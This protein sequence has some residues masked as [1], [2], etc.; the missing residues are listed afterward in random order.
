MKKTI[1][2]TFAALFSFSAIAEERERPLNIL[3]DIIQVDPK[4]ESLVA[5]GN[6]VAVHAPFRMLS[7]GLSRD[8]E[9]IYHF[10]NPTMFT[11]CTNEVGNLH[12]HV[13]GAFDYK[14]GDYALLRDGWVHL[15]ELPLLWV[16]YLRVPLWSEEGLRIMPGYA[17]RWGAFLMTKYVYHIAGKRASED[18]EGWGLDGN[19]RFDLRYKQGVAAGQSFSWRLGEFGQGRF[20]AYYA[21]DRS[22]RYD[23]YHGDGDDWHHDHW[24]SHISDNRYGI[25]FEHRWDVTE[26]DQ[27]RAQAA[28]F[29]DSFF[30]VDFVR[31]SLFMLKNQ[32]LGY[33]ANELAWEH[34]ENWSGFGVSVSGPLNDFIAGT[35]RLPEFYFDVNPLPVF[36]LPVNYESQ[37]RV[38]YLRRQYAKFGRGD[39]VT[40]YNRCPGLWADYDAVRFDT[41]HRITAPMKFADVL[42]V[43]PRVAYRG[44]FWSETGNDCLTGWE[45]SHDVSDNVIR[46]I[47]EGGITFAARGT[48]EFDGWRHMIEPYLDVLAQKAWHNGLDDGAR[49]YVFD[50]VDASLEWSD[51]FASRGRNLPYSWYGLTPGVRNTLDIA[52]DAGGFRR[53]LDFDLYC[54]LQGNDTS[55]LGTD[56]YHKLADVGKPNYGER[57]MT[58]IP[59]F[60]LGWHPFS[61]ATLSARMEYDTENDTVAIGGFGWSHRLTDT[62][63]YFVN[64][65]HNDFR[66]WDYSSS[67]YDPLTMTCDEFNVLHYTFLYAGFEHELC[68]AIVWS[69]Y[70]RWDCR[71]DEL[72]SAGAWIDYRTDCLGFRLLLEFDEP[73]TCIDG[74]R[75]DR[76]FSVGFFIYLRAFGA[77]FGNVMMQ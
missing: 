75:R 73:Y 23:E 60:R 10:G 33:D 76:D 49:P 13:S 32:F 47:V 43:V 21:Y 67:P 24:G 38:G 16:P 30:Q 50:A 22:D 9:D 72:D 59:G 20:K 11:T 68:D 56:R 8:G 51:Q 39:E 27:L 31:K 74:F 3:A 52:D 45:S 36:G 5:S 41:Y 58:A 2:A 46:S 28:Y 66:R 40:A 1:L 18:P 70:V 69:P 48:A 44:T 53:Y 77:D 42:S 63:Q 61:G 12:W 57:D 35:A 7:S 15:W 34:I 54:V 71:K 19:T 65:S 6:V 25:Q 17:G 64:L 26:R 62:F 4:T 29:S 14:D 55:W 37:N